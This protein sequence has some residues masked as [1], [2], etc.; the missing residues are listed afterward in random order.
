MQ[1]L[2]LVEKTRVLNHV[3]PL[4]DGPEF[5]LLWALLNQHHNTAWGYKF[6][7]RMTG[8]HERT[9]ARQFSKLEK[10]GILVRSGRRSSY[11]NIDWEIAP[12]ILDELNIE[13]HIDWLVGERPKLTNKVELEK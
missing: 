9:V 13:I 5:K 6:L 7:A 3:L 4:L 10:M 12:D 8:V 11:G 1:P 2:T